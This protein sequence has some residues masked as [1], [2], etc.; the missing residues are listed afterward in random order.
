MSDAVEPGAS[1][2]MARQ[3]QVYG[4]G[5]QGQLPALPLAPEALEEQAR[6]TLD[7]RA[8]DYVAGGAG[9]EDTMRANLEAFQRWRIVPRMLRNV[10]RCSLRRTLLG[11]DLPAPVLL[12]PIGVQ[13]LAHPEGEL[14]VARATAALGLPLVL[15]VASSYTMEEVARSMGVAPRWFQLYWSKHPGLTASLVTRAER[16]GYSAIV[17]TLDTALL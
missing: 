4:A 7:P 11:L 10:E 6:A 8:Y 15:S 2:G 17:V 14:A 9:A 13:G 1:F 16:A 5:L 12:A 3:L